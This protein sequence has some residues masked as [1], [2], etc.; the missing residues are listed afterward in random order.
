MRTIIEQGSWRVICRINK[1]ENLTLEIEQDGELHA[2]VI[3]Q[4]GGV[5]DLGTKARPW[6][7]AAKGWGMPGAPSPEFRKYRFGPP[8]AEED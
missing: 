5:I 2:D 6:D 7:L 3:F 4:E 8:E 1:D